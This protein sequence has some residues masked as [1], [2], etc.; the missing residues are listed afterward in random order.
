MENH[1]SFGSWGEDQAQLF[2]EKAGYQIHKR[3]IRTPYGEIDIIAKKG[4]VWVIAE[5]KTRRSQF[6]G[7]PGEAVTSA[8]QKKIRQS[9][10]WWIQESEKTIPE[11]R[12]DV[13]EILHTS[14]KT[15][16]IHHIISAF[17]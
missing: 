13:I 16:E 14:N 2:L 4:K 10:L 6:F 17:E 8:K 7:R 15:T 5:V 1:L 3:N 12:F 9:T 11:L